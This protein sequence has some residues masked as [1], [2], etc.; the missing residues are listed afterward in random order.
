MSEIDPTDA[1]GPTDVAY[2][3]LMEA[4]VSSTVIMLAGDEFR[5]EMFFDRMERLADAHRLNGRT[6]IADILDGFVAEVEIGT[7]SVRHAI[8]NP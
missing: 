2:D 8:D 4:W 6:T 7:A 1:Y 3:A 5:T